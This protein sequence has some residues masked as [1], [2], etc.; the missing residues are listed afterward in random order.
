MES[1]SSDIFSEFLKM[2][3]GSKPLVVGY[4]NQL[5]EFAAEKP[6]T[7]IKVKDDVIMLYPVPTVWSSHVLIALDEPAA[8]AIDALEDEEI[9]KLAW[10]KHGFRT[11]VSGDAADMSAFDGIGIEE[12]VTQVGQMPN[13]RTMKKIIDYLSES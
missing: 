2:G 9:Q 6:D 13:Y 11:G 1:S 4:E 7:W 12:T 3:M 10:E 8:G 5:L